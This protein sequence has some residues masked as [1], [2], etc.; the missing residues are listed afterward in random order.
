MEVIPVIMNPKNEVDAEDKSM[1]FNSEHEGKMYYFCNYS[2]KKK[3]DKN[4]E[5]FT[6][7]CWYHESLQTL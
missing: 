5:K 1:L 7:I 4:P 6:A 2:C 3:F